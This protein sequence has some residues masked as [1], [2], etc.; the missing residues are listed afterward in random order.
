MQWNSQ[1]TFAADIESRLPI[2]ASARHGFSAGEL[3][4]FLLTECP[5]RGS[6]WIRHQRRDSR[7]AKGIITPGLHREKT[8]RSILRLDAGAGWEG[9]KAAES[10]CAVHRPRS[11]G[12]ALSARI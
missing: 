12:I 10:R 8:R 7:G 2:T 6:S 1:Q 9:G 11:P 5:E 4:M 3:Q